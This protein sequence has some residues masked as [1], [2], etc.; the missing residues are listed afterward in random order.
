[1]YKLNFLTKD[2][3]DYIDYNYKLPIYVY[4]EK[5]LLKSIEDFN[6]FPS[7]FWHT[8]R[9]AMK[10]NSNINIL[11]L[12]N[13]NGIKIDA[14]SEFEVYRALFSGFSWE[15]IQISSQEIPSDL[16][17]VI[18]NNVFFIATSLHQLEKKKKIRPGI[19][20][21]VRINPWKGSAAFKKIN[22]WWVSSSF[23]IWH[24][25]IDKIKN[26]AKKYDLHI[27]KIHI[28]I[29][30]E[31]TPD[32]WVD[33]VNIGLSFVSIFDE[34]N[35]LDMW[36]WFKKAIMPY[37]QSADLISI[38][39]AVK[40]KIQD[41][42]NE[43]WRKIHLELEP[44]KYMVI[45]SCSVVWRVIDIVDTW[46]Y[47]YKFL[48]TNTWMTE[49]PRTTMYW[50]Q[51]PIILLNDSKREEKYVVVWHCCESWDIMTSKLYNSEEIEEISLP[52]ANIW[53]IIIFEWTGAYNSSMSMKNYNSFPEVWELLIKNGGK[54]LEIRKRE[55][56]KNIYSNEINIY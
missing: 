18:D 36:W 10:A 20:I 47:W 56:D 27:I 34:V 28:H 30:S 6:N 38:W 15:N 32:S 19:N 54:I 8:T 48:R 22:T 55:K 40:E 41:F 24:E 14:S 3:I 46:S 25:Y 13:E 4:S 43:T 52:I 42:Y 35:T 31:N 9:Y 1:M 26:T 2:Q 12:F 53:D 21:W 44:W 7:V 37:E 5:E 49:M 51:Q 33:S 11:K 45:N 50:I 39:N 29:W 23:W 16:G 17:K